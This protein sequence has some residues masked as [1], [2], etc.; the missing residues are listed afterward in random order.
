MHAVQPESLQFK[1]VSEQLLLA[2]LMKD[3]LRMGKIIF[4]KK[5]V[6]WNYITRNLHTS[7]ELS[8]FVVLKHKIKGEKYLKLRI[9][10]NC[11]YFVSY[12]I[13]KG[14]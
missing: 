7:K 14:S 5:S 6:D 1:Q 11:R 12:S 8:L 4:L 10:E 2:V 9:F 13:G 3:G